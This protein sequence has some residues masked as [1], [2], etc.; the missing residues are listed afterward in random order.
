VRKSSRGQDE[1]PPYRVGQLAK[2]WNV[3]NKLILEALKS[4]RLGG[5]QLNRMWLI[6][7]DSADR[8]SGSGGNS[9]S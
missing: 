6:P 8:F 1:R 5:F 4:G 7:R 2:K 9:S 3:G